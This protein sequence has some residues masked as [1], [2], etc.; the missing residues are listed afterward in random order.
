MNGKSDGYSQKNGLK[1]NEVMPKVLIRVGF[2]P[3]RLIL[4]VLVCLFHLR[5]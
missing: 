1:L 4:G 5:I 2:I 3:N